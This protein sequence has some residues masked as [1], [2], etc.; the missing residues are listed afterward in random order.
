MDMS[1]LYLAKLVCDT[2]KDPH[3][4]DAARLFPRFKG[5][6][7]SNFRPCHKC[8]KFIATAITAV[9]ERQENTEYAAS[10]T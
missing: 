4:S 3:L 5:Q 9:S 6:F 7:N 10:Q 8:S 2:G 1:I